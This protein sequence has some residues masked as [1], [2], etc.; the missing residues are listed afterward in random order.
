MGLTAES[1]A[2]GRNNYLKRHLVSL[3]VVWLRATD[4]ICGLDREGSIQVA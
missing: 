3:E 2:A 1:R 4:G